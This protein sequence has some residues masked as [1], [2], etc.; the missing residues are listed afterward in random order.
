MADYQYIVVD[1][2]LDRV[3]RIT[4]NRPQ[5][6][7]ALSN[8]LRSELFAALEAADT[9]AAVAVTIIRG[10]G[11]CFSAGYDLASDNRQNQPFHTAAGI[12]NWPRH[13]AEG[14]FRIW[15]LAKP[16]IGQVH[17]HCLAGGSELAAACDLVYVADDAMIGYPAVRSISPPDNQFYPWL[18]GMRGAMELMLTGDTM[19][20][21]EA[22]ASGFANRSFPADELEAR[23]LDMAARV[24]KIPS[25]LQQINKRAV[26]RQMEAMGLRQGIRAGTEMQALAMYT[27]STQAWLAQLLQKGLKEA[28]TSRDASFGDGRTATKPGA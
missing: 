23:T 5:K 18:M 10:A 27:E 26:H 1:E 24:A 15:D 21:R 16:V 22:A 3:R 14:C 17:G 4:L 2:P 7:N 11:P 19:S 8:A 20:G 6:R 12:G 13:V 28:L 25:D 9:D